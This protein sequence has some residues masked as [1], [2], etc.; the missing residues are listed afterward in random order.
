MPT[1][2]DIWQDLK[3]APAIC[4]AQKMKFSTKDFFGG[5]DQIRKNLRIWSHLL[6][7]PLVENFIFC[8]V[9]FWGIG[10]LGENIFDPSIVD[11]W[12][13]LNTPLDRVL[14]Q[15]QT[16]SSI[17]LTMQKPWMQYQPINS[18]IP[19]HIW[20]DFHMII[21]STFCPICL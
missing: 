2:I 13:V 11:I 15:T 12:W 18:W 16:P 21:W 19:S 10:K 3:Y 1:G 8:A 17:H 9:V 14:D 5:C 20:S 4:T 7:K 6:K